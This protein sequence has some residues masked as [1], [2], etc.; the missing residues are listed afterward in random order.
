MKHILAQIYIYL[1]DYMIKF[2]RKSD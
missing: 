1:S 2:I